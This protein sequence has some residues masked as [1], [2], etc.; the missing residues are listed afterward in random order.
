MCI[1]TRTSLVA[2]KVQWII[3]PFLILAVI[4]KT[5][6]KMMSIHKI[7][8]LCTVFIVHTFLLHTDVHGSN[9]KGKIV[10]AG[11]FPMSTSVPEGKIGRGVK[12][13][14]NLALKMINK[15]PDILGGY[16]L[17]IVD[18]DTKVGYVNSH[19]YHFVYDIILHHKHNQVSD[20]LAYLFCVLRIFQNRTEQYLYSI[21]QI[22]SL[23]IT[24]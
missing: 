6:I 20:V 22:I 1:K 10:I 5:V 3:L 19:Q 7:Y 11:L 13:A 23:C 18:N 9:T 14:V 15:N 12:P 21:F 4:I 2:L 8:V 16:Q 24:T 17:D